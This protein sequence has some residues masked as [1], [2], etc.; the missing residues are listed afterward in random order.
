MSIRYYRTV[1]NP[2][3]VE[4]FQKDNESLE[5]ANAL[6]KFGATMRAIS[7]LLGTPNIEEPIAAAAVTQHTPA[8]EAMTAKEKIAILKDPPKKKSGSKKL[9]VLPG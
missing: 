1:V 6:K 3:I 8:P 5:E 2:G 4:A 9:N 7:L